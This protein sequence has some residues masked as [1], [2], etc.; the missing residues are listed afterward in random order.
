MLSR[1]EDQR[2]SGDVAGAGR[3]AP[4]E[5]DRDVGAGV[6]AVLVAAAHDAAGAL[7][8]EVDEPRPE[9]D[10][11]RRALVLEDD[12]VLQDDRPVPQLP[13]DAGVVL[14]LHNTSCKRK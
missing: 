10:L 6:A 8:V 11:G 9:L 2:S 12:H 7:V 13:R 1:S 3:G 5:A 4:R 14:K